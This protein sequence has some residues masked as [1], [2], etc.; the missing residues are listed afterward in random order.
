MTPAMKMAS[1][2][3]ERRRA[4]QAAY[5]EKNGSTPQ[6]IIKAIRRGIE[7]ELRAKRTAR[8]AIRTNEPEVDMAELIQTM[9]DEMLSAA[10]ELDFEKAA[11]LRD[12]LQK[13]KS[14]HA[15]AEKTGKSTK[16]RRSAVEAMGA[17]GSG[18]GRNRG[19]RGGGSGEERGGKDKPTPGA[20]GTRPG[21][22][23]R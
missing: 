21:K 22:K 4:K 13:L 23:R 2:E 11:L 16:T 19:G 14:S 20:P 9:Q 18:G 17:G 7:G 12:Q 3:T 15:E 8:E 5:N 6:T 1:E 10:Q